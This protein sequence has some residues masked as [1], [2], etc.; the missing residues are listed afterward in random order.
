MEKGWYND[1]HGRYLRRYFDGGKW[2]SQVQSPTG[3]VLTEASPGEAQ[4][5]PT[6]MPLSAPSPGM[7]IGGNFSPEPAKKSRKK[8]WIGI[9]AGVFVIAAIAGAADDSTANS[10]GLSEADAKTAAETTDD[11]LSSS[12]R[13][14]DDSNVSTEES[15]DTDVETPED[16]GI[17]DDGSAKNQSSGDSEHSNSASASESSTG[18]DSDPSVFLEYISDVTQVNDDGVEYMERFSNL[19]FRSD[20]FSEEWQLDVAMVLVMLSGQYD[21]VLDIEAPAGFEDVHSHMLEANRLLVVMSQTF[22]EGVDTLD[23]AK[24]EQATEILYQSTDE[25]TKA[26]ALLN[27]F[28]PSEC[29]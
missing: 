15:S 21:R 24:I 12:A 16:S 14:A 2:T 27:E 23:P 5:P 4:T 26:T 19:M 18:S 20:A 29:L 8:M 17:D 11:F 25:T 10:E 3:E 9:G 13:T 6:E 1:P 22:A 7:Q 28:D